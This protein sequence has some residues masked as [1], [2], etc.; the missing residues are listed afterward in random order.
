MPGKINIV[1]T[2]VISLLASSAS[3]SQ[4]LRPLPKRLNFKLSSIDGCF[5]YTGKAVEFV[6]RFNV[7]SYVSVVM[8]SL[9]DAG[10][11]SA[12]GEEV[13]IPVI[14]APT[15]GSA[16]PGY[17]FGPLPKSRSYSTSF[18]PTAAFGSIGKVVI[19]ERVSP[20]S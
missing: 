19:C 2:L 15:Y 11:P 14:D 8:N 20:P 4:E 12:A 17:W 18:M 16:A 9:D 6:G 13:R 5:R 10:R 7:G 3:A 1:L